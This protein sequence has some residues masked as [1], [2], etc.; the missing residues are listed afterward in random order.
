MNYELILT[1]TTYFIMPRL[2]IPFLSFLLVSLVAGCAAN[3]PQS[4]TSPQPSPASQSPA[5]LAPVNKARNAAKAAQQKA[6]E[7]EQ[8]N[9]EVQPS[10]TPEQSPGQN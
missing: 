6:L 2:T 8:M 5:G 4:Q 1:P 9:P 7:H 3:S 10:Q